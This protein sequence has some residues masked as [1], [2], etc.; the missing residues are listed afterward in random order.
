[1]IYYIQSCHILLLILVSC[2]EGV[3][4]S[5]RTGR[6]ERVLQMEELSANRCSCIAILW[7]SLASFAAI[8]LWVASQWLFIVNTSTLPHACHMSRPSSPWFN[9][10]NNIRWRIQAVKFIIMHFL[11]DPSSSI[12]GPNI[13]LNTLFWKPFR[14]TQIINSE[15]LKTLQNMLSRST[16]DIYVNQTRINALK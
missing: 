16:E 6:L 7:V 1:M 11:H 5:C 2:Y 3:S 15:V 8:T 10:P 13:L 14:A 12:L 9:H 4:K